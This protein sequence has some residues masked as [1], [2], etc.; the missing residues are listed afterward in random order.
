MASIMGSAFF[1]KSDE[2]KRIQRVPAT[3][4]SKDIKPVGL[5]YRDLVL[6]YLKST[7]GLSGEQKGLYRRKAAEVVAGGARGAQLRGK[8]SARRYGY[9]G[10]LEQNIQDRIRQDELQQAREASIQLSLA[11]HTIREDDIVRR[12]ALASG[13]MW[14]AEQ[15]RGAGQV[16]GV[17]TSGKA[18][19]GE[20]S[21]GYGFGGGGGGA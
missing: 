3:L 15:A 4:S 14:P 6:N 5:G 18:W 20:V 17:D 7:P 12:A 9:R 8:A 16:S 10:Q 21:G 13:F 1:S 19:G 2:R 11:E